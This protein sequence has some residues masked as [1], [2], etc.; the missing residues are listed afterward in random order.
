[1]F[2]KTKWFLKVACYNNKASVVYMN[3][4]LDLMVYI[5]N[6]TSLFKIER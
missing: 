3:G 6:R 1:M 5:F 2:L 4:G